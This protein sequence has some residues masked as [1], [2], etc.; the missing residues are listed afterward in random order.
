MKTNPSSNQNQVTTVWRRPKYS[1]LVSRTQVRGIW[2]EP[3]CWSKSNITG[4]NSPPLLV[5]LVSRPKREQN[6]QASSI[7]TTLSPWMNLESCVC[8][9]S[10]VGCTGTCVAKTL[11]VLQNT[12]GPQRNAEAID[13]F[14]YRGAMCNLWAHKMSMDTNCVKNAWSPNSILQSLTKGHTPR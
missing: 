3:F 11:P 5:C 14:L 7:L 2:L 1:H 13:C 6:R 9:F 10:P 4:G 12:V 8:T